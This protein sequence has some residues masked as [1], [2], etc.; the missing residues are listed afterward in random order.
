MSRQQKAGRRGFTLVELLVVIAIIAILAAILFPV[1]AQAREKARTTSCLSNMKQIGMGLQ[2]YGQD[3]DET[4]PPANDAVT[5]FMLPNAPANFL[6]ALIPYMRNKPVLN[7]PSAAP[8]AGIYASG[9]SNADNSTNYMGNGVL[10]GRPLAVVPTPANVVYLQELGHL[11]NI[12]WLR[13]VC[14]AKGKCVAWCYHDGVRHWYTNIHQGGGNL[15]F[16]DGHAKFRTLFSMRSSDFGL[17]PDRPANR[18]DNG[19]CDTGL[20]RAF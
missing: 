13:P 18:N 5:N 17:T 16:G 4:L 3:Y 2:M 19:A 8:A 7:C 12:A 11:M 1:F 6:G 14:D 15:V 10:M 9:R 20:T